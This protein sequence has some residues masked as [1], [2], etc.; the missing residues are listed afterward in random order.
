MKSSTALRLALFGLLAL[1]VAACDDGETADLS[2]TSSLI[3]SPT[4]GGEEAAATTT[5]PAE[6]AGTSTSLVGQSVS[7]YEVVARVSEPAGE[8]LFIVIPP[9][10]YTDVDIEQFV[11]GLVDTG[12]VTYGAE[13]FDDP[14]AVDAYRKPEAERTEGETQLIAQH[15]FASVQNGTTMIFRGPFAASGEFVIGS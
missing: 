13:V 11:V 7:G 15:H 12:T 4:T 5:V 8:T 2:T 10:A 6:A 9:G 3:A 1:G 14:G